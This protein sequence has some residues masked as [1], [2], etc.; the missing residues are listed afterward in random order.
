VQVTVTAKSGTPTMSVVIEGSNDNSNWFTLGT[1]G[2]DGY[3]AGTTATAPTDFSNTGTTRAA[4]PAAQFIRSRSVIGG[5]SP[6]VTYS[7][8]AETNV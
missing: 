4:L 5:G 1:I 8:I 7:V 2:S 6:S 3:G